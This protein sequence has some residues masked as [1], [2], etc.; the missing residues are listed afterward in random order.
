MSAADKPVRIKDIAER[1]GYSVMTVHNSLN[2]NTDTAEKVRKRVQ[3]IAREMGYVPNVL[4][5]ALQAKSDRSGFVAIVL[6]PKSTIGVAK[7]QSAVGKMQADGRVVF[8]LTNDRSLT[9]KQIVNLTSQMKAENV[10]WIGAAPPK[11]E[12]HIDAASGLLE[13][14]ERAKKSN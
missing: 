7:L 9:K 10:F 12:G 8:L 4:A 14:F 6:G 1:A 11:L 3:R 5:R 2:G 13:A